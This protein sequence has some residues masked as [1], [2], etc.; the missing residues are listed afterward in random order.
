M[1]EIGL[2]KVLIT[3]TSFCRIFSDVYVI[4]YIA[5]PPDVHQLLPT[6]L[7]LYYHERVGG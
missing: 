6:A 2:H 4:I 1:S 3:I 7:S 5:A